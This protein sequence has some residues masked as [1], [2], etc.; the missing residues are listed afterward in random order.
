[1]IGF[2]VI[3]FED[4]PRSKPYTDKTMTT[5]AALWAIDDASTD[6]QLQLE[7]EIRRLLR[8]AH[9]PFLVAANPLAQAI[10]L[11][12]GI[13]NPVDA[14]RHAIEAAFRPTFQEMRLQKMLLAALEQ[15]NSLSQIRES[16]PVSKRHLHRRRAKAVTI[17]AEHLRRT[18]SGPPDSVP[19]SNGHAADPLATL[20]GL[21]SHIE[22]A[23]ASNLLGLGGHQIPAEAKILSILERVHKGADISQEAGVE[24]FIGSSLFAIFAAQAAEIGGVCRTPEGRLWAALT[25]SEREPVNSAELRFELEWLSLIR[26]RHRGDVRQMACVTRN[27]RRLAK[28]R[29]GWTLRSLLADAEASIRGA[30]ADAAIALLDDA[31][32]LGARDFAVIELALASALRAELALRR[33]ED[34]SAERFASGAYLVL[35]GRH[36]A[37][38]RCQSVLAR[39]Q[40]RLGRRW[41]APPGAGTLAREAWDRVSLTIESARHHLVNGDAERTRVIAAEAFDICEAQAYGGLA[42]RAAATIAATYDDTECKRGW[43]FRALRHLLPTRDRLNSCDLFVLERI[44]PQ[45]QLQLSEDPGFCEIL[46][47]GLAQ[48]IP[49]LCVTTALE[50]RAVD[51]FLRAFNAA[52]LES[53]TIVSPWC[54]EVR[55]LT[56]APGS[57]AQNFVRFA[58]DVAEILHPIF[59]AV[60]EPEDRPRVEY[61][62]AMGLAEIASA[63]S[64]AG[65]ARTFLIG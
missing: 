15:E 16:L 12:T 44:A 49:A 47:E 30:N 26:A 4:S 32:R 34:G 52:I 17:L 41:N 42:A 35:R 48:L 33:N 40:I 27:L 56:R 38:Y 53:S 23:L 37:A 25:H 61:R 63:S 28:D 24:R 43:A 11:S 21:I 13:D 55:A 2:E 46:Y 62:L 5:V 9:N 3:G 57:F 22:P 50:R 39:A 51:R 29:G 65:D 8:R 36:A 45:R 7:A 18:I 31:V 60:A 1:M 64:A 10:C 54:D 58:G 20:A 19:Q 14:L 59:Q 6:L